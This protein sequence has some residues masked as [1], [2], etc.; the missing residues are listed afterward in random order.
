MVASDIKGEVP[1]TQKHTT[2][3]PTPSNAAVAGRTPGLTQELKAEWVQHTL[4][5]ERFAASEIKGAEDQP[6]GRVNVEQRLNVTLAAGGSIEDARAT[7]MDF[8]NQLG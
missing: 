8:V 4:K 3:T 7:L 6:V 5:I 2:S 1:M